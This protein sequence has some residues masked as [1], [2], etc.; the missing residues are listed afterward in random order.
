MSKF[1]DL[2]LSKL[3]AK[4]ASSQG[5]AIPVHRFG[6]MSQSK[7][8]A[9]L[10]GMSQ[11]SKILEMWQTAIPDGSAALL[12]HKPQ[13]QDL[14][15]FWISKDEKEIFIIKGILSSGNYSIED[16]EGETLELDHKKGIAGTFLNLKTSSLN[17]KDSKSKTAVQ[18]FFYAIKKRMWLFVESIIA[19]FV[20]SLLALGASFFT[21]QVYDRVVPSQNYSTLI[22]LTI[23]TL[24]AVGFELIMKMIRSKTVDKACKAIDE[25]L[26]AVF[27]GK[28]LDI[29]MDARPQAVGT[30]AAQVR[31][32][33][34]VR[35][36]M[37]S[38]TL[39]LLADAPFAI[40]FIIVIYIIGGPVAYVPLGL[41]PVSLIVGFYAKWKMQ[42]LAE[43]QLIDANEKNGLLID[44]I[45]GIEAIKAMGAEWK[46]LDRWKNLTSQAAEKEIAMRDISMLTSSLTQTIQQ[47][48]YIALIA[49]GVYEINLGHITSGALMA[50]SIISNRALGPIAQ[51]ASMVTQWQSSKAALKGLDSIMNL[52]SDR[53]SD[54]RPIIPENPKGLMRLEE[55]SFNYNGNEVLK[56]I[57]FSI[58]PGDRLAIIGSVGSGKSTLIKILTGLFKP[59]QGRIFFD[60]LDMSHIAPEYLREHIGYLPQDVRLFNGTLREN[61]ILGLPSPTDDQILDAASKTGLD[62]IIQSHPKGLGLQISEGGRGLS[63]GQRQVVGLTRMILAKPKIIILDEPTASMDN[64]LESFVMKNL[65]AQASK[66]ATIIFATHKLPL[67]GLAD[68]VLLINKGEIMLYGPR[69]EVIQKISSAVA[70][71]SNVKAAKTPS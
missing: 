12:T 23:G 67:L 69:N 71:K 27:F 49:F 24:I 43:G 3:L 70:P 51:V 47:V 60:D 21:M 62:K 22:V 20:V 36:F 53:T 1:L 58:S 40:F 19:T 63:G 18:W 2:P 42:S 31:N 65:F 54:V 30:F 17:L 46:M 25:E 26:S 39:F 34:M 7:S 4:I 6:M 61:L 38:S 9:S 10:I 37:T 48:S 50:C 16:A 33:E 64:D 55:I 14:P 45:D 11:T 5:Y 29:R 32:F 52:P 13:R 41:L 35:A 57:N 56:N 68:K 15:L 8:G 44:T 66:D 59:S 28:V